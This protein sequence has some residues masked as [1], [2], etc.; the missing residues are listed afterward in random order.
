MHL[1]HIHEPTEENPELALK[2]Y[3]RAIEF[4]RTGDKSRAIE[5]LRRTLHYDPDF[6]EARAKLAEMGQEV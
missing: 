6:S 4:L 2:H 3:G 5:E 1:G